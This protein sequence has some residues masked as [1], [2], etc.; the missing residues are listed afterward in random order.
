[1]IGATSL[2]DCTAYT[3]LSASQYKSDEQ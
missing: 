2:I 1:M 3:E